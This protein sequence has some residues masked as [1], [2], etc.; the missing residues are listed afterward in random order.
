MNIYKPPTIKNYTSDSN[1]DSTDDDNSNKTLNNNSINNTIHSKTPIKVLKS[2][3][4]SKRAYKSDS[5]SDSSD[6]EDKKPIINRPHTK[7]KT[8]I[9]TATTTPPPSLGYMSDSDSDSTD[10]E[11]HKPTTTTNH[12]KESTIVN[13]STKYNNASSTFMSDSD[14]DSSDNEVYKTIINKNKNAKIPT[15]SSSAYIHNNG[16][17]KLKSNTPTT[18]SST[19]TTSTSSIKKLQNKKTAEKNNMIHSWEYINSDSSDYDYSNKS[20]SDNDNDSSDSVSKKITVIPSGT[21]SLVK[22]KNDTVR[23]IYSNNRLQSTNTFRNKDRDEK[24]EYKTRFI[25][26]ADKYNIQHDFFVSDSESDTDSN[27]SYSGEAPP[28]HRTIDSYYYTRRKVEENGWDLNLKKSLTKEELIRL[29]KR[30]KK[31]C[32]REGLSKNDFH[33][34][35]FDSARNHKLFWRKV[36]KVFPD[37]PLTILIDRSRLAY[38]KYRYKNLSFT[39]KEDEQLIEYV[40]LYGKDFKKIQDLMQRGIPEL[41]ERYNI[42]LKGTNNSNKEK[43]RDKKEWTENEKEKL[44][45][46]VKESRQSGWKSW[47]SIASILGENHSGHSCQLQWER[48]NNPKQ[49]GLHDKLKIILTLKKFGYKSETDIRMTKIADELGIPRSRIKDFYLKTRST[50]DGYEKKTLPEILLLLEK[51]IRTMLKSME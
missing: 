22:N 50:I 47:D 12:K 27:D 39:K 13:S 29:E 5:N 26:E 51:R 18:S 8:L 41:Q 28:W 2:K 9:T 11:N 36:A 19:T 35:V 49:L 34:L 37:R 16:T 23:G 46:L 14:S 1:S 15:A 7:R 24:I 33:D 10:H 48:R 38:N 42:L 17:Q 40:K 45:E 21:T 32:R 3:V 44:Y 6:N 30:V 20:D 31:I 4:T 25:D 43:N